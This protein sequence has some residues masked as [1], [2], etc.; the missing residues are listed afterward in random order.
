MGKT[1]QH[2]IVTNKQNMQGAQDQT[3][4]EPAVQV[5]KIVYHLG[6]RQLCVDTLIKE[7]PLQI[8]LSWDSAG[9]LVDS[10]RQVED[11]N[12]LTSRIFSITMR[13]PGEDKEL[14]IG[15]LLSE[16]VIE[17][18]SDIADI[19][20]DKPDENQKRDQFNL[21]DV[22]LAPGKVPHLDTIERY[23][24]TYSSCGLCGTTS[25][26][27][28]EFKKPPK[29][30]QE[31]SWLAVNQVSLMPEKMRNHQGLFLK[32]GS[33]HAAAL[34]DQHGQLV[35]LFEDIGRH[36]ALDKLLGHL[37][38]KRHQDLSLDITHKLCVVVSGRISFE[39]VQKTVMAGIPVLIAVGAP[40]DLAIQAAKRFDLT[41]IGFANKK[42]FNL[43]YGE[44]RLHSLEE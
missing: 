11:K 30:C 14:I 34:F 42:S 8:R 23:Q 24:V 43:Y 31:K 38:L 32:T 6:K 33:A 21:W 28:L 29:L 19:T 37:T 22:K 16:G 4:I 17:G 25:L 44:W 41:I 15:L 36:N 13:T 40:S 39:I 12:L 27:S 3:K 10:E 9:V 18:Y 1:V 26:K 35:S 20:F 7:Q 5:N 2:N